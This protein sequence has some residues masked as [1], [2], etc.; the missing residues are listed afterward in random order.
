MG[1]E[2]DLRQ[3]HTCDGV[4][5]A[6][7][8]SSLPLLIIEWPAVIDIY[9]KKYLDGFAST[10]KYLDGFAS[11]QKYLDGFAST[12]KYLDGFAS[13]QTDHTLSPKKNEQQHIYHGNLNSFAFYWDIIKWKLILQAHSWVNSL[14][15]VYAYRLFSL[16]YHVYLQIGNILLCIF[17]IILNTYYVEFVDAACRTFLLTEYPEVKQPDYFRTQII[18]PMRE[19]LR[20]YQCEPFV[21]R[22]N[23]VAPVRGS[24]INHRSTI[25]V[26]RFST[27]DEAQR[28]YHDR[29]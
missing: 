15:I 1:W 4:K 25:A 14:Y 26:H 19:V 8:I 20:D 17:F 27:D 11:T 18:E 7:V 9:T 13:T 10:Q 12:Q 29:T 16:Y 23:G 28:F 6:T 3:V 24:W 5:P 2:T 22:T 21:V